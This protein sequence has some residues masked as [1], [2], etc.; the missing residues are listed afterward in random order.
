MTDLR[1]SGGFRLQDRFQG[2]DLDHFKLVIEAHA[3]LHAVSW[4]YKVK[5]GVPKLLEKFPLLSTKGFQ[6]TH[7]NGGED[8][9]RQQLDVGANLFKDDAALTAGYEHL[10][11]VFGHVP[12]LYNNFEIQEGEKSH[13]KDSILRKLPATVENEGAS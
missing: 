8:Y 10:R 9:F 2:L 12:K 1:K 7:E 13:T 11:S 4:A 3:T 6:K 5:R